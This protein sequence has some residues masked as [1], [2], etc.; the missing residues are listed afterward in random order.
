[1]LEIKDLKKSYKKKKVVD[2]VTLTVERGQLLGVIGRNGAGKS[3]LMSMI[4]TLIKPDS[5]SILWDGEDTTEHPAR[6][7]EKLGYVPQDIALYEKLSGLDNMKFWG[8]SSGVGGERLKERIR[9]VCE[10]IN[11]DEEM[12]KKKVENYS[13][14]MKRRLNIGVALLHDP[15][16]IILDEPTA[17]IDIDSG[18]MVQN[19]IARLRDQGK[20][21]IYVGH[22]L[23]EI[24]EL[25]THICIMNEGKISAMGSKEELLADETIETLY[26]RCTGSMDRES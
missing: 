20:A 7:R 23:E 4:A 26:K 22:Y 19:A 10:D 12:L 11:F 14:G 9:Q 2:G 6:I 13:G 16:L 24:K 18:A 8:K 25:A 5:G 21:V 17:G 3:T 15:E 1:M